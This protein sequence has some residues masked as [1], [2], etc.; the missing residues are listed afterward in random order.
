MATRMT[1]PLHGTTYAV[2][3]EIEW[4]QKN[5]WTI[6]PRVATTTLPTLPW[7]VYGDYQPLRVSESA[8]DAAA[9]YKAKYGKKP[10]PL[11]KPETLAERLK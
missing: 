10:H 2:G 4:N 8:N 1:H 6:E 3:A 11:M 5:G 7:P 9:Q